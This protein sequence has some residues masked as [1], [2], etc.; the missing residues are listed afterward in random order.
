MLNIVVIEGY[1]T[2]KIWH[3]GADL[4]FRL[5]SYR[6][7]HLPQKPPPPPETNHDQAADYLTVRV[8]G[9]A[10]GGLPVAIHPGQRVRVHGFLG[11]R[12]WR[13]TLT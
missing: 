9:G 7:S 1:V 10:P 11:S 3:W 6:D 13:R 8:V 12:P 5:A 4:C 2:N